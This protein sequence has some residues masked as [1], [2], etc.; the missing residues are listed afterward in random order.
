MMIVVI[1]NINNQY[2]FLPESSNPFHAD[3]SSFSQG[4]K[5]C[6]LTII[7]LQGLNEF[8]SYQSTQAG[9]VA[10][11]WTWNLAVYSDIWLY[12]IPGHN[13]EHSQTPNQGH[14]KSHETVYS[15]HKRHNFLL[16]LL[17]LPPIMIILMILV[18]MA[19]WHDFLGIILM[20]R[21]M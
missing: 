3:S 2:G 5:A 8:L 18:V 15:V 17:L 20:N 16:D 11:D 10:Q 1:H 19:L 13:P 4:I 12:L 9:N 14:K 21:Y 7:Y 6:M